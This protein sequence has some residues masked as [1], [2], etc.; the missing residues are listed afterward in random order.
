MFAKRTPFSTSIGINIT[1]FFDVISES[2]I[3]LHNHGFV[4]LIDAMGDDQA[5]VDAARVSYA[6]GTKTTRNSRGLIRYLFSHKH[7]SPFE[8]AELKFVIKAPIFIARQWLRHRTANVNE[9][10]GRYSVM[11]NE[12]YIP[13]ADYYRAQSETNK[14]GRSDDIYAFPV[15]AQNGI[16]EVSE[17]AFDTYNYLL[18]YQLARETARIILPL[19]T[20]TS[21]VWKIDLHNLLH[22][23]T[24]RADP[25]AQQEIRDYAEAIIDL[26][27]PLFPLTFE[28]WED[29]QRQAK[30][31]SRMDLALLQAVMRRFTSPQASLYALVDEH[32]GVERLGAAYGMTKREIMAFFD[33]VGVAVPGGD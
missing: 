23:L 14:Q 2:T 16:E 21:W 10:S 5:I 33:K 30:T 11:E 1:E 27:A 22:F 6:K 7:F 15:L 20:Y 19:N 31:F 17:H 28:A 13:T 18:E 24:L 25:H 8:M 4:Q 3:H 26:V 32:R 12:F 9:W 29:Y